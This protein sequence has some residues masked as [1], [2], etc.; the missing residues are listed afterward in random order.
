[1]EKLENK[2]LFDANA[3]KAINDLITN[4]GV[5]TTKINEL[6]TMVNAKSVPAPATVAPVTPAPAAAPAAPAAPVPAPVVAPVTPAA[7]VEPVAPAKPAEPA[8]TQ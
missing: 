1:M 3:R 6:T 7:P 2:K 8:P 5:L 4:Q